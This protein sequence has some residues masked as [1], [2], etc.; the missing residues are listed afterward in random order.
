MSLAKLQSLREQSPQTA[1]ISHT[2][3]KLGV[4]IDTLISDQLTTDL[5]VPMESLRLSNLLKLLI[6]LRKVL[7]LTIIVYYCIKERN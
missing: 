7:Y 3:H 4:P 6:E 1:L 5:G 2:S